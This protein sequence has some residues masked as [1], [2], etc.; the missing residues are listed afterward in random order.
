M[1]SGQGGYDH[2]LLAGRGWELLGVT[3]LD[4]P[5]PSASE[6]SL[7]ASFESS[8]SQAASG[9]VASAPLPFFPRPAPSDTSVTASQ[10]SFQRKP[11]ASP[12]G[13]AGLLGPHQVLAF[14]LES[15]TNLPLALD[16]PGGDSADWP[17]CADFNV[18]AHP[19]LRYPV[20]KCTGG[21]APALGLGGGKWGTTSRVTEAFRHRRVHSR[22]RGVRPF[23]LRDNERWREEERNTSEGQRGWWVFLVLYRMSSAERG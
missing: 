4:G 9:G 11:Q 19:D 14:P 7:S 12:R 3:W 15:I 23:D 1:G 5:C 20:P 6:S 13:A 10:Q 17:V 16:V 8:L 22:K 18:V 21:W 2:L